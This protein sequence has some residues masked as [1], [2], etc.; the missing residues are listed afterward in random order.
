M[1]YCSADLFT[2]YAKRA[3]KQLRQLL[4][5]MIRALIPDLKL[6]APNLPSFSRAFVQ[7][8]DNNELV[9]LLAYCPEGRGRAAAVEDR[10]PLLNTELELRTDGRGIRKVYLA[11]E[12]T[13]LP[14][15]L[16]NGYCKVHI[17][18]VT[19]YGLVVFEYE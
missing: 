9:H 7:K 4:E 10:I 5:K 1:I 15:E 16:K 19:G 18:L 17:P 6:L 14:F 3:P 13:E 12:R 11:S 8:K 2:G